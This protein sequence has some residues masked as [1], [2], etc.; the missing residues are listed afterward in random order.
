MLTTSG[1]SSA[2]PSDGGRKRSSSTSVP[3]G[4]AGTKV[5]WWTRTMPWAGAE[6]TQLT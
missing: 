6:V 5:R 4:G 1:R 3:A 2:E